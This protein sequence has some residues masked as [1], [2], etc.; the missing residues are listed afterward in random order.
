[1]FFVLFLHCKDTAFFP[2]MQQ[3]EG[4]F[5]HKWEKREKKEEAR[6]RERRGEDA[7]GLER[8]REDGGGCKK[9]GRGWERMGL[10]G[11]GVWGEG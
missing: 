8:T 6:G 7:R 1:L 5:L 10:P 4:L 9:M 2:N 3:K 11:G